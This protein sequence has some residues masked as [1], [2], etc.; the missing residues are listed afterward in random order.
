MHDDIADDDSIDHM[1]RWPGLRRLL[2]SKLSS[3][4]TGR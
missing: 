3:A 2:S 1:G 4:C